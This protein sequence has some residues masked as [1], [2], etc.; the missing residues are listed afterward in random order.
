M[1]VCV[2]IM[3][4]ILLLK[5]TWSVSV[6]VRELWRGTATVK[7]QSID[8]W[9]WSMSEL[10]PISP[11]CPGTHALDWLFRSKSPVNPSLAKLHPT[12]PAKSNQAVDPLLINYQQP[13]CS[14]SPTKVTVC[15]V[16]HRMGCR[17]GM[18]GAWRQLLVQGWRRR[19]Y[20]KDKAKKAAPC[21][22]RE[23]PTIS[24]NWW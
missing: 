12:L 1:C 15:T 11:H 21:P 13:P 6:L 10:R 16:P 19:N 5:V 2:C 20:T 9:P 8:N 23:I 3:C 18:S 14:H 4:R 17:E 22:E 24:A 7:H